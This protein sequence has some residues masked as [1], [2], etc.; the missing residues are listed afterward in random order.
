MR[1]LVTGGAGYIGSIVTEQLLDRGDDVVAIDNLS[2]GHREAVD[3]RARF[4]QLDLGDRD[5]L[6]RL[7]DEAQP[8]DA[9]M[10]F[11]ANAEVGESMANPTKYFRNNFSNGINLVE[12]LVKGGVSR[13]V[14]SSTCATYGVP[15]TVPMTEET[16]QR[17]VNPYGESKLAF[18]RALRWYD[19]LHGLRSV[20]L[21][22]F[23]AAGA[24]E[25]FGEDHDPETHLVPN[26]LRVA[27][28]VRESIDVFGNDYPTP[29][30]TCI[31]DYVHVCDL[32]DAHI[33]ALDYPETA[34]FNL[35]TGTGSSVLEVIETARAITGHA[36]PVNIGPR[37]AGDPP[38][39]VAAADRARSELGWNPR[40]ADV[41]T[42]VESAWR[43][44][45]AHP[46]GYR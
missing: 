18:E 22:Y 5:G 36:I 41:R 7:I 32:G 40:R 16:P 44:H 17:P 23:N 2:L 29:D 35:G 31:R 24:S 12:A 46:A 19:E 20:S 30:G 1:I 6:L 3:P 13:L 37:R 10:H 42:I 11:A 34:A 15:E 25:R 28:G 14:F 39:L 26:V 45:A 33:L 38:R 21:R 8:F 43:W 4:V 9:A 27:L